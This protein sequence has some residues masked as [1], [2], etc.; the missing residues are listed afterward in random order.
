[1]AE[2]GTTTLVRGGQGA[3]EHGTSRREG[4]DG[5]SIERRAETAVAAQAEMARAN[6][7]ARF[8]LARMQPR[9][10]DHAR[11]LLLKDCKRPGFA[12]TARYAKP[13]GRE[14][15]YGPS[16]R[17]AEAALR[18]FGNM[19]VDTPVVFDDDEKRIVRVYVT[20]LETNATLSADV[21]VAKTVERRAVKEGQQVLGTRQNSY[22]DMLYIV[23]ATDDEV[24][25]KAGALISKARRNLTLQLIPADIVEE[26][27]SQVIKTQNDDDAADP[28]AARRKLID[29]FFELGVSAK[30]LAAYLGH[31]VAS[32]TPIE[33]TNL[34]AVYT[35]L[36]NG[37]ATWQEIVARAAT[38]A[39]ETKPTTAAG[40]ARSAAKAAVAKARGEEPARTEPAPEMTDDGEVIPSQAE[41][42]AR[43]KGGGS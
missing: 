30:D 40:R 14:K 37:E 42:D 24:M 15:I 33:R 29:A 17:F 26:C 19:S 8:Q 31:E 36:K 18:T 6:V 41:L 27:M 10:V 1:M 4:M 21:T 35:S 20:D 11:T 34:R 23:E 32:S 16:V 39:D 38:P 25:Q 7:L 43:A 12:A 28:D 5:T 13:V 2:Q 9:D 22:G 3:L